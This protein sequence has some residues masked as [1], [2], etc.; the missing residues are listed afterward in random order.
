VRTEIGVFSHLCLVLYAFIWSPDPDG[1][2]L[3]RSYYSMVDLDIREMEPSEWHEVFRA[4]LRRHNQM[5]PFL[6]EN[7]SM[8]YY[9]QAVEQMSAELQRNGLPD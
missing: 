4:S 2:S 5:G 9:P 3:E 1:M 6:D 7:H 8:Y